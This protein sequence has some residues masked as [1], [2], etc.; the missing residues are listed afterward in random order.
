M[1]IDVHQHLWPSPF[2][3]ALRARRRPPRL[4]GWTLE[5]YGGDRYE[6]DPALHDPEVRAIGHDLICLAPSAALGH[7]PPRARGG[8]R[9]GRGVAGGRRGA[10][11]TVSALGHGRRAR[12]RSCHA[13][14]RPRSG[15][16]RTRGGRRYVGGTGRPGPAGAP[17]RRA[18]R[19][20]GARPPRP[21]RRPGGPPPCLVDADGLL[22]QPAARR[23]VGLG[24]PRA[25]P[26]S[27]AAGLLRR[28]G[29][30]RSRCTASATGPAAVAD[31]PVDPLTFVETSSYGT[32]AVDAV[33]RVLG[34]DVICHGSDRPYAEPAAAGAR[35]RRAPRLRIPQP[36]APSRA[37]YEGG[38]V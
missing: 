1:P 36:R 3:E 4:E 21:D 32:Q 15:R 10:G 34:V 6:I 2:V 31:V 16:G 19:A 27:P 38:P 37:D 8:A 26:L 22:R 13:G 20:A 11:G 33:L 28:A 7:R 12:A 25:R 17:V 23:L 35:P 30:P 14:Q 9:A 5:L 24:G 18:R 29:R